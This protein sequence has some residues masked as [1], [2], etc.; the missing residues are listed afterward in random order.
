MVNPFHQID[1]EVLEVMRE[2]AEKKRRAEERTIRQGG[3]Q[4]PGTQD[5][6]DSVHGKPMWRTL[7]QVAADEHAERVRKAREDHELVK[8]PDAVHPPR[9]E[10]YMGP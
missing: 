4:P 10:W 2:V 5:V 8:T 1:P 9:D 7:E 3:V 6:I